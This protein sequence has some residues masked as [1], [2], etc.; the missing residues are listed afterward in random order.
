MFHE[1]D[2]VLENLP[3]VLVHPPEYIDH[4][5]DVGGREKAEGLFDALSHPL[6]KFTA[7]FFFAM[8]LLWFVPQARKFKRPRGGGSPP[9]KV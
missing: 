4:E 2:I 7:A 5:A 3:A 8:F 9:S 1:L 6:F